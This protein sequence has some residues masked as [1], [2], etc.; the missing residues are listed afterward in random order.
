[1]EVTGPG[2]RDK[3]AHAPRVLGVRIEPVRAPVLHQ[4][5]D[6]DYAVAGSMGYPLS[7]NFEISSDGT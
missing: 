1:M 4:P 5:Q 3:G 6:N 2:D 7:P